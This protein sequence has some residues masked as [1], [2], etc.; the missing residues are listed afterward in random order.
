MAS[1]EIA[2][3]KLFKLEGHDKITDDPTDRGGQ[4]KFGIS[5]A[6]YPHLDIPRITK[7]Q[8]TEI[9][10]RD[11]WDK[12]KGD[13]LNNQA[14][15]ERIFNMAVHAHPIT[16]SKLAQVAIGSTVVPDGNIGPLTLVALNKV[17]PEFFAL[18]YTLLCVTR[19][20]AICRKDPSQ[21]KYLLGWLNRVLGA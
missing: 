13:S 3:E 15:A 17:Q 1:F 5:K 2:L 8:A 9:Y 19:Y 12:I 16:A 14:M 6:A 4:T 7:A 10:R 21:K 18:S 20:V 11:F